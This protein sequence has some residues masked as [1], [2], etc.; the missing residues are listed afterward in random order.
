[1]PQSQDNRPPVVLVHGFFIK[2]VVF[3]R[4]AADLTARGWSV[5]TPD[6]TGNYRHVGLEEL[7]AQLADYIDKTFAPS[8]PIDLV[9]LS[10]GGLVARYY[11]QRLS[12]IERVQRFVSISAP[13]NGTWMAHLI[14]SLPC[15][16][17]RPQSDFLRNLNQDV[18]ML[19]RVNLTYLWTPWDFIIVPASSSLLPVGDEVRLPVITHACMARHPLSMAAV[20]DALS[21]PL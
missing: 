14:P 15:V 13:H 2:S 3:R 4:L 12:G 8:Q 7:A 20:A 10:M 16:Q 5:H 11:L 1:M 17:M 9:G 18:A 21:A 6:F 19:D